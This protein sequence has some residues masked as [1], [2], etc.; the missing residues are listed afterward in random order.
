M[1]SITEYNIEDAKEDKENIF[2]I[3]NDLDIKKAGDRKIIRLIS[4]YISILS[5]RKCGY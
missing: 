1:K 5:G 4:D 3:L 2:N